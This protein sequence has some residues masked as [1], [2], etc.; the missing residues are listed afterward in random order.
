M[1]P[2]SELLNAVALEAGLSDDPRGRIL[3]IKECMFGVK[4][5]PL[6]KL[7]RNGPIT[8]R[9]KVAICLKFIRAT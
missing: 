1:H 6:E 2:E 3:E 5:W 7:F 8:D 9:R 4:E